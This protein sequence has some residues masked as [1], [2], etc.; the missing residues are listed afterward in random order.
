MIRTA[1]EDTDCSSLRIAR[2]AAAISTQQIGSFKNSGSIF[3]ASMIS[4]NRPAREIATR[5]AC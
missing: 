4:K 2:T 5:E 1:G 3:F